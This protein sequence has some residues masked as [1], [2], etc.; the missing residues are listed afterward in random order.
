MGS[1]KIL[2]V[3]VKCMISHS[4]L[5]QRGT[6]LHSPWRLSG[7]KALREIFVSFSKCLLH[8]KEN[9]THPSFLLLLYFG[10]IIV[11]ER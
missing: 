9:K 8:T 4:V 1:R 2:K 5:S 7:E 3:R 11:T 6:E 10:F